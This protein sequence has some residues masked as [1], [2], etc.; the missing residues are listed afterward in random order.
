M[1]VLHL[2]TKREQRSKKRIEI[3]LTAINS[4]RM[5]GKR[6]KTQGAAAVCSNF[7]LCAFLLLHVMTSYDCISIAR[8]QSFFF[9]KYFSLLHESLVHLSDFFFALCLRDSITYMRSSWS[10]KLKFAWTKEPL[11]KL[12]IERNK[13]Q[14]ETDQIG[15]LKYEQ[16]SGENDS[17]SF[18]AWKCNKMLKHFNGF[19]FNLLRSFFR[20]SNFVELFRKMFHYKYCW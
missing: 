11:G 12:K 10:L 19:W 3:N 9:L 8:F 7:L 13:N 5:R 6:R 20:S 18:F 4:M 15:L 2:M 1:I 14:T 17:W 16:M